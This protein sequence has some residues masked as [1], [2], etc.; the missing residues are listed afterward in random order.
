[1]KES[2]W[3]DC[4]VALSLKERLSYCG[5]RVAPSLGRWFWA[6]CKSQPSVS[7]G[8][9]QSVSSISPTVLLQFLPWL[10]A[11]VDCDLE[12]YAK[13][14]SLISKVAFGHRVFHSNRKHT[15]TLR[16][17]DWLKVEFILPLANPREQQEPTGNFL[18][19]IWWKLAPNKEP[20]RYLLL[21]SMESDREQNQPS[22][23]QIKKLIWG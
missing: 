21:L 18:E 13:I 6:A 3:L 20:E 5:R 1:M 11:E 12:V 8:A 16:T 23:E 17:S 7:Q 19:R 22:Q 15:R 9:S 2:S 14:N 10:P 4:P